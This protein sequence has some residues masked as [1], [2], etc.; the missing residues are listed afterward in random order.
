M[1]LNMIFF[2]RTYDNDAILSIS[3]Q[4]ASSA[5]KN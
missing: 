4:A 3:E 1:E 5:G 2:Y